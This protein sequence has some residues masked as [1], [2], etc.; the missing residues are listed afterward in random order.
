M[1]SRL[2]AAAL[3]VAVTAAGSAVWAQPVAAEEND[4]VRPQPDEY[5]KAARYLEPGGSERESA[6]VAC[7]LHPQGRVADG[8]PL[9]PA[10]YQWRVLVSEDGL[11]NFMMACVLDGHELPYSWTAPL[12]DHDVVDLEWIDFGVVPGDPAQL[13]A[14]ALSRLRPPEAGIFTNPGAGQASQTSLVGITTSLWLDETIYGPQ[15]AWEYDGPVIGG[16]RLLAVRV[17]ATPKPGG[18]VMWSTGD[19]EEICANGGLPE[20]SCSHVYDRSS[21]GQPHSD[22]SGNPAFEVT[23]SYSYTG[24]YEVYVLGQLVDSGLL[25]DI[26]RSSVTYLGVAEAQAINTDGRFGL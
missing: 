22:S 10:H 6:P 15:E 25:P 1:H 4:A 13:A 21:A 23:A 9:G 12:P 24:G 18:Q 2:T 19:G 5:S 20:G 17:W 26:P 7:E 3:A 14:D 8:D 11:L 16:A